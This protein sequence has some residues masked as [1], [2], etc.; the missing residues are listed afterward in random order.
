MN[1]TIPITS[2]ESVKNI[3]TNNI[4]VS[5]NSLFKVPLWKRTFDIISASLLIIMISPL[6]I[7][8]YLAV[9]LESPGPAI[10]TSKRVGQGFKVFPFY[11]FRSMYVN[12]EQRVK[13][14]QSKNQYSVNNSE[15]DVDLSKYN[16]N[17]VHDSG[18]V[19]ESE[20]QKDKIKS[21]KNTFFKV[22]DD[23]RIT[24]VGKIIR[25]TSLDELPQLFNVLKGHMSLVGNRPLPVYEAEK[26]T[27][28]DWVRR[29]ASPSGITGLWQVEGR[30]GAAVSSEDR[31]LLDIK[32]A[33]NYSLWLDLNILLKTIPA[34][35]QK[36]NV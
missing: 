6:L 26:L 9:K 11:K 2:L 7:L 30:G 34:I 17:L 27:S 28:D 5:Q 8:I 32:Y 14:M 10:Y 31:K 12:A 15:I 29:F 4:S 13:E 25:N 16:Q 18:I 21:N 24:P 36:A 1:P 35:I 23:V 19:K 3:R 33:E 22:A 20:F